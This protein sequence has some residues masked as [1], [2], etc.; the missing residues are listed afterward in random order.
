MAIRIKNIT[1][2]D[3]DEIIFLCDSAFG[4]NYI[5]K[6]YLEQFVF[7]E[8]GFGFVAFYKNE[9]A[10]FVLNNVFSNNYIP[11]NKLLIKISFLISTQEFG[12]LKTMAIK[13]QYQQ[14][15]IGNALIDY[16]LKTF[17]EKTKRIVSII[18][19]HPGNYLTKLLEKKHFKYIETIPDFWK[20]ESTNRK[21]EC[22]LCGSPPCLCTAQIWLK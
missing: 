7:A 20:E 9:L 18:W 8:N 6:D 1:A 22:K 5:V 15:G 14:K 17:G 13:E 3:F 21:F 19:D 12:V 10:G 16:S 2:D 11:E 4:K